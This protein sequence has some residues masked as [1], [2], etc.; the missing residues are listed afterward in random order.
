MTLAE[1]RLPD[2][3]IHVWIP[4]AA[5]FERDGMASVPRL[6]MTRTPPAATSAV[7]ARLP[8]ADRHRCAAT[9]RQ[10]DYWMPRRLWHRQTRRWRRHPS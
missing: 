8:V 4:C 9:K 3:P 1:R 6:G 5:H 2:R 10:R 7:F